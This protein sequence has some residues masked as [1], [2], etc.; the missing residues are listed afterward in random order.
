[1]LFTDCRERC[2]PGAIGAPGNSY[3][4]T[5]REQGGMWCQPERSAAAGSEPGPTQPKPP[6][7]GPARPGPAQPGPAAA[8]AKLPQGWAAAAARR[9]ERGAARRDP[10]GPSGADSPARTPV[11]ALALSVGTNGTRDES[12]PFLISF[13]GK[14]G[15]PSALSWVNVL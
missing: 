10:G 2:P 13:C 4:E 11:E 15:L 7:P 12:S 6:Q 3:L 1:M 9:A 5:S 14:C 8:R